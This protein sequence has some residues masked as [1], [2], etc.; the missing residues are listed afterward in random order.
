MSKFKIDK[1]RTSAIELD[2]IAYKVFG[3]D[4][5][6]VG[7]RFRNDKNRSLF[8]EI[9]ISDDC[10]RGCNIKEFGGYVVEIVKSKWPEFA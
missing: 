7:V 2:E 1:A 6:G 5:I 3:N 8:L 4:L 10:A 9:H